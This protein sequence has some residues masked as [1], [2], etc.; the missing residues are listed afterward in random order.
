[1]VLVKRLADGFRKSEYARN[2]SVVL[3]GTVIAF[4]I[5]FL[6]TPFISRLYTDQDVGLF[7]TFTSWYSILVI[8]ATGRYEFAVMLPREDD[9]A[10][11]LTVLSSVLSVLFAALCYAALGVYQVFIGAVAQWVWYL[12]AAVGVLGVYYSCNYLLNRKKRYVNLSVNKMIQAVGVGGLSILFAVLFA[13]RFKQYGLFLAYLIA[14]SFVM[15]LLILYTVHEYR[16]ERERVSIR[17]SRMK[18]LAKRYRHFL[19]FS[20]P[21]GVVNTYANQIPVFLL[22]FFWD[23]G[24]VGQYSMMMRVLA[25]PITLLGQSIGDVFRQRASSEYTSTGQCRDV[26]FKTL[27]SLAL[28]AILP[29]GI[30]LLFSKP[31]LTW[32]FGSQWGMAA[33][34]SSIMAPFFYVKLVVSPLTFMTIV[35]ERQ[36]FEMLWQISMLILSAGAMYLSYL[37]SGNVYVVLLAFGMATTLLYGVHLR[38]TMRLANGG[39]VKGGK[40]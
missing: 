14:Q 19:F 36:R 35:A 33:V 25:L 20:M 10:F 38:Y 8:V 22:G 13:G 3:V 21:S 17:F 39:G 18:E 40:T 2:I 28:I 23:A 32:F 5:Q 6:T 27:R 30:L 31:L 37:V 29:F 15:L 12:P 11:N 34:F 1:M 7:Q 24:I 26:Y 16:K 4:G 9:D